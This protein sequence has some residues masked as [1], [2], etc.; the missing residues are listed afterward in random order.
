MNP[1]RIEYIREFVKSPTSAN[2]TRFL[3]IGCGGGLLSESLAR[4]GFH[5]HGIDAALENIKLAQFHAEQQQQQ[6]ALSDYRLVYEC[7]TAED[8]A[9][10]QANKNAYDVLCA[11]EIVEHVVNVGNFAQNCAQLVKVGAILRT[12]MTSS[13]TYH[14]IIS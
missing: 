12:N 3:D 14:P 9:A 11:M 2:H 6:D 5:V 1:K 8:L 10:I 4:L 13:D 7:S